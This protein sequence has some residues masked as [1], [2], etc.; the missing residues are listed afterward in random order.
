MIRLHV[1]RNGPG[2]VPQGLEPSP[3]RGPEE[4][5]LCQPIQRL[6]DRERAAPDLPLQDDQGEPRGP[7]HPSGDRP[8]G[9]AH[10]LRH[11]VVQAAFSGTQP[12]GEAVHAPGRERER[13]PATIAHHHV[14][15]AV[16]QFRHVGRHPPV[17]APD[18]P[19]DEPVV[20][21]QSARL[22]EADQVE[23][24]VHVILDRGGGQEQHVLLREAG[25]EPP[26]HAEPILEAMGLVHDHEVP[27]RPLGQRTVGVALRG[28]DRRDQERPTFPVANGSEDRERQLEL[29]FHLLPP[30]PRQRGG[31]EDQ[32]PADEAPDRILLQEKPRLDRLAEAHLVRENRTASHLAQDAQA[33]PLLV[34]IPDDASQGGPRQQAVEPVDEGDPMHLAVEPPCPRPVPPG[35]EGASQQVCVRIVELQGKR[36]IVGTS[37]LAGGEGHRGGIPSPAIAGSSKTRAALITV[38]AR[39]GADARHPP[40]TRNRISRAARPWVTGRR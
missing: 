31:R 17:R 32:G 7:R 13:D 2:V 11:V 4:R 36:G 14:P 39:R 12:D 3:L 18:V 33:C 29:R 35:A 19:F 5:A 21:V 20:R 10:E 28:V 16:S 37:G 22:Q 27:R 6:G 30:L 9:I 38:A 15:E 8:I 25:D 23:Q 40:R 24:L 1:R 26:V 34:R